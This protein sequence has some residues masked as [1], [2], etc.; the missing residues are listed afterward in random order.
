MALLLSVCIL[1][2][3]GTHPLVHSLPTEENAKANATTGCQLLASIYPNLTS[4]PFSV[5]YANRTSEI[6]SE[7]C[8]E[9][10]NCVFEPRKAK[11]VAGAIKALQ[12]S[13]TK[14]AVRGGGHMPNPGAA[15]ISD[16]V[17]ISM[18]QI[19][20]MRLTEGRKVAQLGPGLRWGAVYDWISQYD[21]AV[22]GGRYDPVGV[23]GLLL[24]GGINYFGSQYGWAASM[25]ANFQVVLANGSIVDANPTS[26]SDLFWALKG[27]SSNFGIVTRF[28]VKTFPFPSLYGGFTVYNSS[29]LDEFL[30]ATAYFCIPEGGSSDIH[31]HVNPSL[32]YNGTD[33]TFDIYTIISHTGTNPAPA[34]VA[35][36]SK[37]PAISNDDS[38]R[39]KLSW[40]TNET[41][42]PAYID[43]STREMFRT[44]ALKAAP[45]SVFLTN[46]TFFDTVASMPALKNVRGIKLSATHQTITK[47][48]LTAAQAAGGDPMDLDPK[49]G[50]FISYL[51]ASAWEDQVDDAI[52]HEFNDKC[53]EAIEAQAKSKGLYYGFEYLNDS[54]ESERVFDLYGGGESLSKMR[55]IAK[56]YD[57]TGVFQTL[58]PG[59]FKLFY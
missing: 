33:G 53:F 41:A 39:T 24:G 34:S 17:L 11:D 36:Y 26:H 55:A 54:P 7:T 13:G 21:L 58:M 38:V 16:G 28:D 6:W 20:E 9:S 43:R 57:P 45:E 10:P 31:T 48:W 8:L 15:A 22:V 35:N 18:T 2:L 42:G 44:T 59:G 5:E 3:L 12:T 50:N 32:S 1:L 14:F 40:F 19:N 47:S 4:F 37:I 52:I 30:D 46:K 27:G 29:Y 51:M 56:A 49:N 25:V 23:P